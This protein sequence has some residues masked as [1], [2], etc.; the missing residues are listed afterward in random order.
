VPQTVSYKQARPLTCILPGAARRSPVRVRSRR[1]DTSPPGHAERRQCAR[2]P[3]PADVTQRIPCRGAR[4]SLPIPCC[5]QPAAESAAWRTELPDPDGCG[6]ARLARLRQG[7]CVWSRHDR[8][9]GWFRRPHPAR[10]A[11]LVAVQKHG[12]AG[13][14]RCGAAPSGQEDDLWWRERHSELQVAA[15]RRAGR[16]YRLLGG[17]AAGWRAGA[18][19]A[20]SVGHPAAWLDR[21]SRSLR[22]TGLA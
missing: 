13:P 8:R 21:A 4:A 11:R 5:P 22:R 14:G 2:S 19:G 16:L 10:K 12:I 1:T 6:G 20:G 9:L 7:G 3:Q 18:A 15:S 17:G